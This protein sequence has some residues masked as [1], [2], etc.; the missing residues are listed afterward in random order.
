MHS[1]KEVPVLRKQ[2]RT[3]VP[4]TAEA[5]QAR[6]RV[7]R[8]VPGPGRGSLCCTS[9]P[10]RHG[11]DRGAAQARAWSLRPQGLPSGRTMEQLRLCATTIE[12]V[13]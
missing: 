11:S 5:A 2:R 12:P 4:G 1:S 10:T 8:T 3:P 9:S 6:G 13:F 7:P